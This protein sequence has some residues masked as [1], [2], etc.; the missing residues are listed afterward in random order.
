MMTKSVELFDKPRH[1]RSNKI[2]AQQQGGLAT[3]IM[4]K[5]TNFSPLFIAEQ[6]NVYSAGNMPLFE[7]KRRAHINQWKRNL[8]LI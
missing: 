1:L 2:K 8:Q 5:R 7:L 3:R 6:R 4:I